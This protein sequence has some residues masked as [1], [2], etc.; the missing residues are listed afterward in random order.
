[1][2]PT[3]TDTPNTSRH[4]STV[5]RRLMRNRPDSS[6]TRLRR[7]GPKHASGTSSGSCAV[8]VV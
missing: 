2:H 8:V 7:F 1:M 6:T 3:D 4:N 5:S